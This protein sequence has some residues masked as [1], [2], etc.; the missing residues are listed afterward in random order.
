M[1]EALLWIAAATALA[2][3]VNLVPAFTPSTWIVLSFFYIQFDLPLLPLVIAGT[4][5][6]A[7]G[8][9]LLAK[10]SG[11]AGRRFLRGK[12]GDI[13]ELGG[14]LNDHQRWLTPIVF[15]YALTPLPTNN[16][17]VAAGV[18]EV[19]LVPVVGGFL[20]SRMIANT[21][22]IWTASRSIDDLGAAFRGSFS[23]LGIA[24]QIAGVLSIV[25]LYL[26]PW[27]SWLRR[28]TGGKRHDMSP[29]AP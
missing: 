15:V 26:L 27:A 13:D 1:A 17:F 28:M 25:A 7:A 29:A 20:A 14:F 18:A 11:G 21:L 5:A 8:R 24:I 12:R 23:P 19:N 16:L 3:V 6:S 10:G 22:W 4:I 2:F 9:L